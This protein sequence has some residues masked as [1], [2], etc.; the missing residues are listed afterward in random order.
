MK[1]CKFEDNNKVLPT[2]KFNLDQ[3]VT[4]NPFDFVV[5]KILPS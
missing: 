1:I 2:V 5:I 3:N 4:K